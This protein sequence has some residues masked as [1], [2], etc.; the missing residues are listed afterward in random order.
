M[1]THFAVVWL[2]LFVS[3]QTLSEIEPWKAPQD[4]ELRD[5][6]LHDVCRDDEAWHKDSS[7]CGRVCVAPLAN[8]LGSL[9]TTRSPTARSPTIGDWSA[10]KEMPP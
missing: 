6:G 8:D 3:D 1:P 4:P 9:L 10:A 5:A 7:V 2:K